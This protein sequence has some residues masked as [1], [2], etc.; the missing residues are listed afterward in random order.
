[1]SWNRGKCSGARLANLPS[2]KVIS[3]YSA[4]R[5]ATGDQDVAAKAGRELGA[6]TIVEGSIQMVGSRIRVHAKVLDVSSGSFIWAWALDGELQDLLAIQDEIAR[7]V[8]EA[9]TVRL[10]ENGPIASAPDAGAYRVYLRGRHL[11]NKLTV[12]GCEQAAQC[13]LRTISIAP[14]YAEGYAALADAYHWLIFLGA[15]TPVT[16]GWNDSTARAASAATW[17]EI[18]R[19]RTLHWLL[20]RVSFSGDGKRP[21]HSSEEGWNSG[22]TMRLVTC[23]VRFAGLRPVTLRKADP[24]SNERWISIRCPRALTVGQVCSRI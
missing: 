14:E 20:Q 5:F 10:R 16:T 6:D 8:A 2:L 19:K 22:P 3:S 7:V 23:S 12:E 17:T 9:L 24:T 1:M 13:F 4:F 15:R 18:A 21:R 11:W